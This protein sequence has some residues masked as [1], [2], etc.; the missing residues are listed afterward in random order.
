VLIEKKNEK[1]NILFS[2]QCHVNQPSHW[3]QWWQGWQRKQK[4]Q[5]KV[6]T[7]GIL[8]S[9]STTSLSTNDLVQLTAHQHCQSE[10]FFLLFPHD[11]FTHITTDTINYAAQQ[12]GSNGFTVSAEEMFTYFAI[13]ITMC[14][15][16]APALWDH[17][18]K[19]LLLGSPWI[20]EKMARDRWLE[21]HHLLHFDIIT[22][23]TTVQCTSQHHWTPT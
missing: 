12:H 9:L 5:Q 8:E 20:Y 15:K 16:V 17:W 11:L 2:V 18:S 19:D 7:G 4:W 6:G 21:I 22:V 23:E 1:A 10:A 14:I 13:F 3:H